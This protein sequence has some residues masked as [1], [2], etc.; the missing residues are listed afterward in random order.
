MNQ[1][2]AK[3]S[4]YIIHNQYSHLPEDGYEVIENT[5]KVKSWQDH[6]G[7]VRQYETAT[8][9]LIDECQRSKYK[10]LKKVGK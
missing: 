4:R 2:Q 6:L 7:N 9:K 3:L 1:K 8:I 5:R 10:Q